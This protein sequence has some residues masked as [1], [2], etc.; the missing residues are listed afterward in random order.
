MYSPTLPVF[1]EAGTHSDQLQNNTDAAF[2]T[3]LQ[4]L[5]I[6]SQGHCT[7]NKVILWVAEVATF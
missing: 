5:R 6:D 2:R 7:Q 3:T 1:R 4:W